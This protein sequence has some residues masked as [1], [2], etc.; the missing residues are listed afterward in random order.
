MACYALTCSS[1]HSVASP[2]PMRDTH[3]RRRGGGTSQSS[4]SE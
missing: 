3:S 2:S 1:A 4:A